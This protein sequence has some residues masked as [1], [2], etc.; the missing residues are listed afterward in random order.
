[1]SE[2]CRSLVTADDVTLPYRV[3]GDGPRRMVF[4][5]S[6]AS[7][8][9]DA[10]PLYGPL[11]D[12]GFSI[13]TYDQRG[14]GRAT[15]VTDPAA[16]ALDRFGADLLAVCDAAGW[17]SAWFCGG[18]MGAAT[19]LNAARQAPGRC[20]G[21]GLLAPA[22]DRERNPEMDRFAPLGAAFDGGMDAG[23]AAWE[24]YFRA[25]ELTEDALAVQLDSLRLHD[26]AALAV[27][28]RAIPE[29]D[30]AAELDAL[31]SF[32]RPVA[33]VAWGEDSLHA[34]STAE[35]I[36]ATAPDGR[37]RGIP[38]ADFETGGPVLLFQ[39]LA[40]LVEAPCASPA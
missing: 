19:A 25:E 1:M 33:V 23:C 28:L 20:E 5:H 32:A 18:S 6:L 9:L 13:A 36:A 35:T 15:P 16:Y 2:P 40:D 37:L 38:L 12:L 26:A 24:A 27:G 4:A 22:F 29:W 30:V 14:F 17:E 34:M 31:A 8:G 11:L 10:G 3:V 39:L 7:T 21:L